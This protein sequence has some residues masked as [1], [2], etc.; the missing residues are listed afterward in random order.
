MWDALRVTALTGV[1]LMCAA[2][3]P[4]AEERPVVI[5]VLPVRSPAPTDLVVQAFIERDSRNRAVSFTVDSPAFYG[6]STADLDGEQSPRT[7]QVR[8]RQVPAGEYQVQVTLTRADGE[9]TRESVL[10]EIL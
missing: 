9:S 6:R 2:H 7:M 5:R 10:M 4:M 1:V 3:Q 8:F